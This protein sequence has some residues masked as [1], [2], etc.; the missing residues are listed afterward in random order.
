M[1]ECGLRRVPASSSAFSKLTLVPSTFFI[2]ALTSSTLPS[3]TIPVPTP[4]EVPGPR[5][6]NFGVV[7]TGNRKYGESGNR[8]RFTD[9]KIINGIY[10]GVSISRDDAGLLK[11]AK[12]LFRVGILPALRLRLE[13]VGEFLGLC[14]S[15]ILY[16]V[17]KFMNENAGDYLALIR[18]QFSL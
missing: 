6:N 3:R 9:L 4:G 17:F 11:C 10:Y 14:I 8:Q 13:R 15:P 12:L 16:R 7:E 5:A 1:R 18:S 2:C